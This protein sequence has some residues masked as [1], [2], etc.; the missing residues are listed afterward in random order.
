VLI[1]WC[2]AHQNRFPSK[3][4]KKAQPSKRGFLPAVLPP[5]RKK[6]EYHQY[7]TIIVLPCLIQILPIT[8]SNVGNGFFVTRRLAAIIDRFQ[9]ATRDPTRLTQLLMI[10]VRHRGLIRNDIVT[11]LIYIINKTYYVFI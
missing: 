3:T 6:S 4:K 7:N 2:F 1:T 9:K 5:D 11:Y 10:I 8:A